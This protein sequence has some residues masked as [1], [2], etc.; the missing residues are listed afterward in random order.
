M[1]G[2]SEVTLSRWCCLIRILKCERELN[3]KITA[4][5]DL[6]VKMERN[7]EIAARLFS[8]RDLLSHVKSVLFLSVWFGF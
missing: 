4:T 5:R 2:P 8:G 1:E 3:L 6:G 7:V